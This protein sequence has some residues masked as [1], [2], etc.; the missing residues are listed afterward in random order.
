MK[1]PEP[2]HQKPNQFKL[3]PYDGHTGVPN[4]IIARY[5]SH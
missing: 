4:S 1:Y 3:K 2:H 5:N